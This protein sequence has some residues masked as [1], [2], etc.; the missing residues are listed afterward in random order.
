VLHH[1]KMIMGNIQTTRAGELPLTSK[2]RRLLLRRQFTISG[3]IAVLTVV[4]GFAIRVNQYVLAG[5]HVTTEHYAEVRS[6]T[7]GTVAEI[8][9]QSGQ[10]VTQGEILV[11]LSCAEERATLDEARS[12]VQKAEAELN[13]REAEIVEQKRRLNE[14]IAVSTL[15]MH[16]ATSR[17]ARTRELFA[18]GLVAGTL[19]EDDQLKEA[20]AKA[21]FMS[22]TNR[23]LSV[24]D[25]ELTVL[26]REFEARREVAARAEVNVRAKEIHAPIAGQIVRYE[27]V[28]GELVRPDTVMYEIF[29]GDKKII[30]L[31]VLERHATKVAVGNRYVAKL[32]SYRGLKSIWFEGQV[33]YL[34]NVIQ[35]DGQSTYRVAYCS[36]DTMGHSVPPGATAEAKIY[37]GR[38]CLWF[39]LFGVD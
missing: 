35:S 30:K 25:K 21:E 8:V 32:G 29:G 17:L 38:T 7:V 1:S 24:F 13:R 18:K 28:V 31:R 12:Q 11:R 16:N 36:F 5:G 20:L 4:A 34:R 26:R 14:D 9:G 3:L 27:F 39:F 15:R 19:M 22:L 6:P 2:E 33:E 37:C 10:T 23:D